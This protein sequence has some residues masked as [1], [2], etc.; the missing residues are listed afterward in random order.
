MITW[1]TNDLFGSEDFRKQ[2]LLSPR[3]RNYLVRSTKDQRE[4]IQAAQDADFIVA[5]ALLL[6]RAKEK[7]VGLNGSFI[8]V[9]IIIIFNWRP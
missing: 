8:V 6:C 9:G 3:T 7:G 5:S 2:S 1:R 4:V